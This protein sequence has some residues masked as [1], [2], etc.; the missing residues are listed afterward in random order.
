MLRYIN[1]EGA[2]INRQIIP[3]TIHH[4]LVVGVI[5]LRLTA[6]IIISNINVR[7]ENAPTAKEPCTGS[8]GAIFLRKPPNAAKRN[9]TTSMKLASNC[10]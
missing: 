3:A 10:L 2:A 9:V 1:M 4:F 7:N 8:G 5:R 6:E